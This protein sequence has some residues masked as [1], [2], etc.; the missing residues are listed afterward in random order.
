MRKAKLSV[1]LADIKSVLKSFAI[2]VSG[3]TLDDLKDNDVLLTLK[4]A[5]GANYDRQN[6]GY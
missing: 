1:Q 2:E 5:M 4:K 3:T 6:S